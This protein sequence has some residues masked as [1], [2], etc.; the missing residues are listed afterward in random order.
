[1]NTYFTESN[2]MKRFFFIV[3][4]TKDTFV[5]E[6]LESYDLELSLQKH[7]KAIGYERIIFYSKTQKIYCFDKHSY[8]LSISNS[9][10]PEKKTKK[11]ALIK[12]SFQF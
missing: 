1:M 5:N 11:K 4:K 9:V 10:A 6:A 12:E 3:G 7:L 2:I 8:E